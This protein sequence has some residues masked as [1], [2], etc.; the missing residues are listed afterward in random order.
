MCSP[1]LFTE[2]WIFP[3]VGVFLFFFLVVKGKNPF[4]DFEEILKTS[5]NFSLKIR[6][7]LL[8]WIVAFS[9]SVICLGIGFAAVLDSSPKIILNKIYLWVYSFF[10]KEKYC[11]LAQW[12]IYNLYEMDA[13]FSCLFNQFV[14]GT[15][16]FVLNAINKVI[17][18]II[19]QI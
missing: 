4:L 7:N 1:C 3:S 16:L 6:E 8:T 13:V 14:Y 2:L 5:S 11:L 19:I 18:F 17:C 9:Y 15:I 10:K 12:L